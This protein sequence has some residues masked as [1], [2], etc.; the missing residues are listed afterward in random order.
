MRKEKSA[1]YGK[2]TRWRVRWVDD[3]GQEH[4]KVFRLKEAAQAHLDKVTADVVKGEYISPRASAITFGEVAKEWIEAKQ[5]RKPKTVA[6]YVSLLDNLVLP[7]WRD[8]KL[9]AISHAE[10]QRWVNGL[11]RNGS[12]RTEGAGLSA[13][14]VLQAHQVFSAVLKYAIKTERLGKNVATG[15]ELPRKA[16]KEHQYLTHDQ[17]W[18]LA[19]AVGDAARDAELVY[20]TNYDTLVLVLAYCG[21][22]IGEARS[23][24][25]RDLNGA[26]LTVRASTTKVDGM[27]YT[28][29]STKTHR[30]RWVPV[31]PLV[32]QQLNRTPAATLT[33]KVRARFRERSVEWVKSRTVSRA[34]LEMLGR[35]GGLAVET[36]NS[37]THQQVREFVPNALVFR[38]RDGKFLTDAEF[39]AVFDKAAAKIGLKGLTPHELRHT[40]ASLAIQAAA[41][42]KAVQRL[43]GHAT[44]SMTLD[45]YGHLFDEDL[46]AVADALDTAM[47]NCGTS[48]V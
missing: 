44:A 14:R 3:S 5:A 40:C 21:L 12:V 24:R 45:L 34:E 22:R 38:G 47:R 16:S 26:T 39:R 15:V 48:A 27:G 20:G 32:W 4:T 37:I 10:V 29:S 23:L 1:T 31:P 36:L 7:K 46:V 2:V 11:S 8:V 28:E 42:V 18:T 33:A 19:R 17:V 6:G 35:G 9:A 13:S 30:T 41:N 25:N 43:L